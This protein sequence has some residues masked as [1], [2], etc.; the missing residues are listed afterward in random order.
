MTLN[1]VEKVKKVEKDKNY[2]MTLINSETMYMK[3][4][5]VS[6]VDSILPPL[7]RHVPLGA[8]FP[9]VLAM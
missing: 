2:K 7:D 8:G 9:L 3:R 4:R 1:V 6:A 5:I